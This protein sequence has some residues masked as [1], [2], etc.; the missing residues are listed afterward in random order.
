MKNQKDKLVVILPDPDDKL[1]KNL[2]G[3]SLSKMS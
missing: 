1:K 2:K 3:V